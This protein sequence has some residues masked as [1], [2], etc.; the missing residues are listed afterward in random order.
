MANL[1]KRQEQ[2]SRAISN[3]V[4]KMKPSGQ[5]KANQLRRAYGI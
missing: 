3:L 1:R 4:A 5:K 2:Q